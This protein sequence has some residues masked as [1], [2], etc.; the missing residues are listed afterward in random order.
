VNWRELLGVR[1]ELG[2]GGETRLVTK[3]SESGE[4]FHKYRQQMFRQ[5]DYLKCK[6]LSVHILV[7]LDLVICE[8]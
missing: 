5:K 4:S 6:I 1:Q 8:R 7:Q 2:E 3:K